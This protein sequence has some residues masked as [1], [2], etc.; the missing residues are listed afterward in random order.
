MFADSLTLNYAGTGDLVLTKRREEGYSSEYF[1]TIGTTDF[2]MSI[3]HTIP[4]NRN[5]GEHSHLVRLD[6]TTY[7]A[8]NQIIAR[9]SSWRVFGSY[10]GQQVSTTVTN[11]DKAVGSFITA[12]N[13]QK[14]L[15]GES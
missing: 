10:V 15:L 7:D 3:K 8:E 9:A 4:R 5:G 6:A 14:L 11:L 12:P 1:G 13:L 2:V